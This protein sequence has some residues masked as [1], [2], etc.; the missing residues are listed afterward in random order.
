MYGSYPGNIEPPGGPGGPTYPGS[1]PG[2]PGTYPGS[3]PG[4]PGGPG[5]P[6]TPGSIAPL[7]SSTE[8]NHPFNFH[9]GKL[10]TYS[11]NWLAYTFCGISKLSDS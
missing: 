11:S 3:G 6:A 7:P 8:E 2:G 10:F 1:G 9:P 4:G 5:G